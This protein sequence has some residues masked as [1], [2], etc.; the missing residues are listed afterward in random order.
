MKILATFAH[1]DDESYGPAGTLAKATNN[2]NIVSMLTLTQ[3]ESGS[4]GISKDLSAAELAKRRMQE[5]QKA[6]RKLGIQHLQIHNLADKNLQNIPEQIGIDIINQEIQ[7][8]KPDILITFHE[9]AISGHPDHLTVAKWSLKAVKSIQKPPILFY[10]GL[11]QEQTSMVTFRKLNPII[12]SEVTH[13]INVEDFI[14]DKIAAIQ[15]HETQNALWQ[16]FNKM[17]TDFKTFAKWEVFVQ[18]WPEPEN[19][20]IKYD[21]FER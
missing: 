17:N 13:K 20:T 4:M 12:N 10:F 5:L 11:S 15:C 1:P 14:S 7:R 8:F 16:N 19:K 9:N 6:A 21:L 3:G 18:K 2:G